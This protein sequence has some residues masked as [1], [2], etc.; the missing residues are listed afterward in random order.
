ME[1]MPDI[2]VKIMMN[3]GTPDQAF[4]FAKLPNAGIG[5][6]R[7]EFIINRQ[8]GIHPKALLDLD[9]LEEPL[10]VADRRGGRGVRQPAGLLRHPGGGGGVDAGGGVRAAP[11]DRADERLQVQRVRQPGG[12]RPVR[13]ARGEP[14]D[15]LPR[16]LA[17]SLA[18]VRRLLRDGVRGTEVRAQRDGSDQRQDHDPVRADRGRGEGRDRPAGHPRSGP[19]GERAGGDHDVRAAVER[20]DRRSVPGPLRRVLDRLERH[21]PADAGSGSRLQPDRRRPSTSGTRR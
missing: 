19:R 7:L 9:T 10:K 17:V 6:A 18:G 13:A 14:D 20:G 15:R 3:V 5:L 11:G 16:C 1:S 21:D 2:P 8:I 12:R 4:S